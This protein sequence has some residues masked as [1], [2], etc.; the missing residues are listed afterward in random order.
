MSLFGS[1]KDVALFYNIN[2][3]LI[4]NV[5]SISVDIYK[6][7]V[8]DTI[9]SLYGESMGKIYLPAVRVSC[10]VELEDQEYVDTELSL[11]ITQGATFSFLRYDLE[12]VAKLVIESGD[13][14]N[15]NG[16][17]W[18]IDSIIENQYFM[19]KNPESSLDSPDHGSNFSVIAKAHQTR[20][21][22]LNIEP[23]R[24]SF[25]KKLRNI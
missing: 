6:T 13:I 5:V 18:E 25:N 23:I 12:T 8:A 22:K 7:S 14:I 3:E 21:S 19:G 15:Y 1:K 2:R 10:L 20:K 9:D 11:D 4:N 24:T 17:Y 16:A